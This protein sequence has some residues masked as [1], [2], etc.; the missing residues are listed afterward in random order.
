MKKYIILISFIFVGINLNAQEKNETKKDLV[1]SLDIRVQYIVRD[2]INAAMKL[3]K[4]SGGSGLIMDVNNGEILSMVSLPDF[5]PNSKITE[6]SNLFN[7]NT[8]GVYEL[9]LIHI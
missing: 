6:E 8:L 5:D 3:Y 7:R 1:T 2:E 9:S 4:A